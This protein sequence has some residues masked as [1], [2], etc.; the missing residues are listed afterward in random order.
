ML[1]GEIDDAGPGFHFS[2][3]RLCVCSV[4]LILS[5]SVWAHGL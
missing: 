4:T 1:P 3:A 2:I 5:D